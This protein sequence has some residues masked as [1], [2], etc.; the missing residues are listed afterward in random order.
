MQSKGVEL[1]TTYLGLDLG[2]PLVPSAG[3]LSREVGMV[4]RLEDY[5]AAAIV[6]YSLFEEQVE[7]EAR[8]L[9]H[10][11]EHGSESYAEGASYFPPAESYRLGPDEYLEHLRRLKEAVSIPVIGSLNGVSAGGW[12]SYARGIEQAGA[13]AIELNVFYIPTDPEMEGGAVEARYLEVL[14]AVKS[15]VRIPVAVK[16]SPYFKLYSLLTRWNPLDVR[17]PQALPYNGRNVLVVGMGP[18]GYTLAHYL[19]NEGFGVIGIDGLKIEPLPD[20]PAGGAWSPP[21]PIRDIDTLR[22]ELDERVL[23]GFGGVSEYGNTVRWDKNFLAVIRRALAAREHFRIYGGVRFGGTL[24]IE[25]VFGELGLDHIAIAA[26][27]GRPSLPEMKNLLLRGVRAASDFL[28]ALQLTGAFK[29]ES[30]ANLQVRL[31]VLVIGGGLTAI[32]AA[33]EALAYY[34][35]QVEKVLQ[36]FEALGA[37]RF[38]KG[39]TAETREVLEELLEH[40]RAVRRERQRAAAAGELPDLAALVECWGGVKVVY[41]KALADSPA[42]RN[43]HEEVQ[44]ALEEGVRF[45]ERLAPVEAVPGAHGELEGV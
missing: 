21:E 6:V 12:T 24:A 25:D 45:L 1:A 41:R 13:D 20:E 15:Q 37:E 10:F 31:P 28:M 23:A 39:S 5:G 30:L 2:N 35:V 42:L 3:P 34:P 19:L 32:D 9:A 11:L 38:W 40:G 17:R 33:T 44:K 29:R 16:L 36:R 43:N 27:A 7:H 8:E 14:K 26:G 22:A 18:A 4:R